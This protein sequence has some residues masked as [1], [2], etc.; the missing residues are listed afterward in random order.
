MTIALGAVYSR[1]KS[2]PEFVHHVDIRFIGQDAF[3]STLVSH[4]AQQYI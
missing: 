1:C 2:I 3:F 4:C